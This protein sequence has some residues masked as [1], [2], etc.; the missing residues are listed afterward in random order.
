MF[1][2]YSEMRVKVIHVFRVTVKGAN[3]WGSTLWVKLCH[4]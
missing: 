2:A 3:K 4:D 1:L